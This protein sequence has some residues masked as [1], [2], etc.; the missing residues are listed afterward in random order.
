MSKQKPVITYS[1]RGGMNLM[2][3]A[4]RYPDSFHRIFIDIEKGLDLNML[5]KVAGDLGIQEKQ[6]SLVF[7]I[8]NLWECFI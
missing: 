7:L 8:K 3:I 6:S 4:K 2:N 5:L 1:S